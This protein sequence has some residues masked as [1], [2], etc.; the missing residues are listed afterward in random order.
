MLERHT[1]SAPSPHVGEGWGGGW[2]ALRC[3][4][5]YLTT[6][7][8]NPS[9]QPPRD[10][11]VAGTPAGGG[12]RTI[13]HNLI[14]TCARPAT[15]Q[16]LSFRGATDLGLARDRQCKCQKSAHAD[17]WCEAEASPESITLRPV[18]MDSGLSASFVGLAPE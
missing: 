12:E 17:F 7:T 4:F 18:V 13:A 6:P 8:P 3:G 16:K 11:S 10:A 1:R 2:C 9:P 14:E 5:L 15:P